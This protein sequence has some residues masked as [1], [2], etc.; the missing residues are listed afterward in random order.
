MQEII[1]K[2]KFN[3]ISKINDSRIKIIPKEK[4]FCH[5]NKAIYALKQAGRQWFQKLDTRFK[6]LEFNSPINFLSLLF[7]PAS[8][9]T[10]HAGVQAIFQTVF[11]IS[12]F[13]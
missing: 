13:F 7:N 3:D 12:V 6:E 9:I 10:N 2:N 11:L 1:A 5:Q 8:P 4:G